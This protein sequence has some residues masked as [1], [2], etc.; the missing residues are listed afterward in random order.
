[1]TTASTPIGIVRFYTVL[2]GIFAAAILAVPSYSV[3][4]GSLNANAGQDV[5][6]NTVKAP[7]RENNKRVKFSSW[8]STSMAP[9]PLVETIETFASDCLTPKATFALGETVCAK[10]LGVTESNRFVNWFGPSGHAFGSAGVTD[11]TTSQSQSFLYTPTETGLWKATIADSTDSSI[12]PVQ[13]SV[14]NSPWVATYAADCTTPKTSFNLGEVVC[15]KVTNA[16]VGG[17]VRLEIADPAGFIR[18][19]VAVATSTQQ[20]SFTLPT[21]ATP[22]LAG[23]VFVDNRGSWRVN[24]TQATDA[25][26]NQYAVIVVHDTAGAVCDLQISKSYEGGTT[27]VAGGMLKAVVWAYNY[28]PDA[29]Q[30]VTIT[31]ET[32]ANTTFQSLVQTD[33]PTFNCT[34]PTVGS[35]GVITCTRSSLARGEVGGFVITYEI[36]SSTGNTTTTSTATASSTTSERDTADNDSSADA[37]VSNPTPSSCTLTCPSNITATAAQG[38]SGA[39]VTFAAPTTGGTCSS[40]SVVPASGSFFAIGTSVVTASTENGETC[41]FTVTVNAAEDNEAP[42]ITCPTDITVDESSPSANSATVTYNVTAT[43]NSGSANVTCDPPSGSSFA[44]GTVQ[45]LCTATDAAGN[46]DECTFNVTVNQV[47]CDLDANSAPPTPNVASLPSITAACS[48]SLLATNDPTA[49]DACGGTINGDITAVNGQAS[50]ERTF[51]SP[52]TY[53]ITWSYTDS[54]GHTTTQDQTITIQPDNSAPVKD[55]A[56][57]PT[58]TG[59]CE[60]TS[61]APPTATDNC[62]GTVTGTTNN[63]PVVGAGTHT[64]VWTYDDGRGNT[65]TQNQTVVITDTHA[66]VVTLTG[67]STVTV[68]C[69]TSYTD[70]GATATDNCSP[71]PTPTSTSNVDVNTPGSYSV[72]WSATDGGNNTATATRTV[73]VVDTTAPV[74]TLTGANPITVILGSTFTDPGATASDSCAG[75][76]AATASGTVNTNAV[77]SYTITY[78]ASDP[79]GNPAVAV[80]RTVKVIYN[81]A[82]FFSP[83]S[84]MPT[85]N[86]VNAGRAVPVKFTLAGDQGL[87]IFAANNPYTVTLNCGTNDPGVDVTETLNAGGSSLTFSGGQYTYVWKTESSWAGT[88]RQLVIT[89]NDGTVH[90]ANFKFK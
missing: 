1:M 21:L 53:V 81:F 62:A 8:L 37:T 88:C 55:V 25:T 67:P 46:T 27:G 82:G 50:S 6:G 80:T 41:S 12:I 33:G 87:N 61:I 90:T 78:N 7:V 44:V 5:S 57:L 51:D 35:A 40:V 14:T 34:T 42:V 16:P 36:N 64:V 83:V 30:N 65:S 47:G 45:V 20:R 60:V 66:P 58:V 29:S 54:A 11:I 76:F 59:E 19:S 49:T 63:L 43:D 84:N 2:F 3:V 15:A 26:V 72:V 32:P 38:Q 17:R 89:L 22:G 28:G 52:G 68:E 69:H 9:V 39:T 13:F 75:S 23:D 73:N 70:A 56:T 74:I 77:G 71:A 18:D 10:T 79:S 4:S 48:V 85:L 24:I 86:S 31:D